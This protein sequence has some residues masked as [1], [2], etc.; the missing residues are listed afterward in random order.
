MLER[1]AKRRAD[2]AEAK[3]LREKQIALAR[4]V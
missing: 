1:E 4:E 2:E 3:I